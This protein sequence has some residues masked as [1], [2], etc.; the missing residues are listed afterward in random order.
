MA[1]SEA[2]RGP[3]R[4]G[5]SLVS[6]STATWT[7]VRVDLGRCAN[8]LEPQGFAWGHGRTC[9]DFSTKGHFMTTK[10]RAILCAVIAA[11]TILLSACSGSDS[12]GAQ[13]T[14][15][16][17]GAATSA[18]AAATSG[19]AKSGGQPTSG[20]QQTATPQRDATKDVRIDT[21]A[22]KDGTAQVAATVT[23]NGKTAENYVIA[24]EVL[25][26]GKRVDGAALL[27]TSVA[28]GKSA[29]T[30]MGGTKSNLK[31][32]VTCQVKSVQTMGG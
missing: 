6:G 8:M 27:A 12:T 26:G 31:G 19:A 7:D 14:D 24:V 30:E 2:T 5:G 32:K 1:V 16:A 20:G 10:G 23:N 4:S 15:A 22:V 9:D 29:K 11:P 17:K 3:E 25:Q 13:A 21:C 28:P 18:G